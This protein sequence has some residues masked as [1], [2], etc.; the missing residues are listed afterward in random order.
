MG[1]HSSKPQKSKSRLPGVKKRHWSLFDL[2]D[3]VLLGIY[4]FLG[5]ADRVAFALSS[6]RLYATLSKSGERFLVQETDRLE[7]LQ[8]F[9]RDGVYPMSILC[10]LCEGFHRPRLVNEWDE[11]EATRAC[12]QSGDSELYGKTMCET[13][14]T[15]VHFDLV[16]AITRSW[17]HNLGVYNPQLLES[18]V[19]FS[20]LK[21]K[22][23]INCR[24][25]AKVVNGSLFLKT[26]RILFT[27]YRREE[28]L[29]GLPDLVQLLEWEN[30]LDR[31]QRDPE[32]PM[33]VE[34]P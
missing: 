32:V 11:K 23:R 20:N 18:S 2:T 19:T 6:R 22:A 30:D 10:T 17:R 21:V 9:E 33:L 8:R 26:E 15:Y 14:P 28:A 1:N 24:T 4:N 29:K 12:V 34:P 31:L 3:N 16:A 13:F 25:E 7:I 27:G 5:P